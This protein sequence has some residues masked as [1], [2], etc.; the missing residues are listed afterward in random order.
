VEQSDGRAHTR[1]RTPLDDV[2]GVIDEAEIVRTT[3]ARCDELIDGFATTGVADL[4]REYVAPMPHLT[5]GAFLGFDAPTAQDVFDAAARP[6]TGPEAA[7]DVH[8]VSFLLSGQTAARRPDGMPTPAG[9]LAQH[10]AYESTAEAA[11]GLLSLTA[12]AARAD[13][14]DDGLHPEGLWSLRS[15]VADHMTTHGVRTGPEQVLVSNGTQ[16]GLSLVLRALCSPG[17]VVLT[18][19]LT[20]PGL[21]DT[22]AVGGF[23]VGDQLATPSVHAAVEE[24]REIEIV[25]T[26]GKRLHQATVKDEQQGGDPDLVPIARERHRA[27]PGRPAQEP[28]RDDSR[29]EWVELPGPALGGELGV[30]DEQQA[31]HQ[32][33]AFML[34]PAPIDATIVRP[35]GG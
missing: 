14:F 22:V 30:D 6:V 1:L 20:W 13:G 24:F 25:R 33:Q 28:R 2:L 8:Q 16:H 3:R 23:V 35:L 5:F 21:T 4:V 12:V 18:E 15:L 26:Q 19:E 31:G 34:V 32:L 9:Q 10:A 7:A 27:R 17:D 29:V 11:L